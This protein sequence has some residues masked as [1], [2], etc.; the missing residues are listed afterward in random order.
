MGILNSDNNTTEFSKTQVS[1][2]NSVCIYVKYDWWRI[3]LHN[4]S[5]GWEIP[6]QPISQI[7][8]TVVWLNNLSHCLNAPSS[9]FLRQ[10]ENFQS[11]VKY[12]MRASLCLCR[13]PG[14]QP[15]VPVNLTSWLSHWPGLLALV[16]LTTKMKTMLPKTCF[17]IGTFF[18]FK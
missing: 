18:C 8:I 3:F 13:L 5:Y 2:C 17:M 1:N 14:E 12:H 7:L 11:E 16:W 10:G 6:S 15:S 4:W 9:S